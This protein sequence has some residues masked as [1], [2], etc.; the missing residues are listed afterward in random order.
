MVIAVLGRWAPLLLAASAC[1][2]A[3]PPVPGKGGPAWHELT[4]EHF[5][6]WT[7]TDEATA[8]ALV[9]RM[10]ALRQAV[11]GIAFAGADSPGRS[12]VIA[13]SDDKETGE[14]MYRDNFV[15]VASG[16]DSAAY[17]PMIL[18]AAESNNDP[19]GEVA[20][21]ELTH[22]ISQVVIRHQPRWFAEGIAKFFE[23][24]QIDRRAGTIE[25]GRGAMRDNGDP[26]Y[27]RHMTSLRTAFAC[28]TA[29]C[30]DAAFYVTSWALYTYLFNRYPARL[31][32]F[33]QLLSTS[34]EHGPKIAE[35]A[36]ATAFAGISLDDLEH[37]VRDW[38]GHGS[39]TVLKFNAAMRSWPVTIRTLGDADVYAA[40]GLLRY[41][42]QGRRDDAR[43]EI[44]AANA[45]DPTNPLAR[46]VEYDLVGHVPADVAN[47]LVAAHPDDWRSWYLLAIAL[48]GKPEG[49]AAYT[50]ACE[51]AATNPAITLGC[52]TSRSPG[53]S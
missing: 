30:S 38:L 12:F 19:R 4:S 24:I 32:Q 48:P 6:L 1:G 33:E 46:L 9:V 27:M 35:Q 20:A 13:L 21:H 14:Y 18:L 29:E 47:A 36:W 26:I 16:P 43:K 2:P 17:Q 31:V 40:R 11:I 15:A 5:T 52:P 37:D 22:N 34:K 8:R 51:L 25:I 42:F 50:K 53:P 23:T 45:I 7:D 41:E 28:H 44:D 39:H 10:E 49:R 3:I